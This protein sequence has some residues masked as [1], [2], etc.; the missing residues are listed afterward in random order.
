VARGIVPAAFRADAK[1]VRV[2]KF[3][4]AQ[5]EKTLREHGE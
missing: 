1:V 5:I 2:G 3:T 4:M